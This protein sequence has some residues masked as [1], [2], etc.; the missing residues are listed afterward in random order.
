MQEINKG[1]GNVFSKKETEVEIFKGYK[2]AYNAFMEM[3]SELNK[4]DEFLVIGGGENP[5]ATNA[6]QVYVEVDY[7]EAPE[8]GIGGG[9][10]VY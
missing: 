9:P 4:G 3:I 1:S 6:T 8:G 5:T 7:D 10:Y 2:G